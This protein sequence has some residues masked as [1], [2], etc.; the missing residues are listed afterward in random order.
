MSRWLFV[1]SEGQSGRVLFFVVIIV[2]EHLETLKNKLSPDLRIRLIGILPLIFFLAQAFHYWRI[3][4]PGHMLWMCNIGNLLLA[5]GL[6]S[7]NRRLTR[8][9][10][11]W[12]I[13]GLFVWF[14]YVV[15]SWG[16]FFTSTLAHVGGLIVGMF[17][18]RQIGMDR[19]TWPYAFGW[20]L[21]IQLLSRFFT[22][23][24]LN[25]NLAHRMQPGWEQRF[26]S[27]W[28]FWL[29]LTIVTAIMLWIVEVLFRNIWPVRLAQAE[30]TLS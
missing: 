12:T 16:V 5:I 7:D 13:P 30:A 11:I 26:G 2:S 10:I 14:I 28:E 4:Q 25:V 29:V 6:F 8:I 15:L 22:T 19:G 9:A 18:L 24:D 27:Y 1:F 20:Y 21:L 23:A 3:G 17:V